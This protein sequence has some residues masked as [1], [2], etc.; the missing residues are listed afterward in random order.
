M[1][2]LGMS[3][4]PVPPPSRFNDGKKPA[5]AWRE[6]QTRLAT[7]DE[8]HWWF[9]RGFV[10]C[11]VITG[12]VSGVVVVDVDD[13]SAF[14]WVRWNL[15]PT[16]WRVKTR[17]GFHLYYRPPVGAKV[18]NRA[19]IA[20]MKLDVRGDGGYVIGAGSRHATG[21]VYE[22][23][24]DWRV[25]KEGIPRLNLSVFEIPKAA[26]KP[27]SAKPAHPLSDL[28]ERGRRYLAKVPRPIVGHGSD[29]ATFIAAC[30]LV[31]GFGIRPDDA[32]ALLHE[33]APDFTLPWLR[34]KV[35]SALRHGTEVTGSLV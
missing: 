13:V 30:R 21:F 24:G 5:I 15:P 18:G 2:R 9:D 29:S 35:E 17:R 1:W 6:F 31:R 26:P 14:P 33:W 27:A 7:K 10:N 3:V 25:R 20:G 28:C 16:P 11:A 12:H 19:K 32:L 8:M 23:A 34:R 22:L 4:I